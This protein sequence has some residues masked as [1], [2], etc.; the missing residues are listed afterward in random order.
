MYNRVYGSLTAALAAG[1]AL[2][3]KLIRG[4]TMSVGSTASIDSSNG[5]TTRLAANANRNVLI[6]RNLTASS[7]AVYVTL[8]GTTA[9]TSNGLEIPPGQTVVFDNSCPTGEVR[10]I[11]ASGTASLFIQQGA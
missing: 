10:A 1:T 9:T 11:T 8:D 5:G 4:V 3:G 7:V 2:I 6:L